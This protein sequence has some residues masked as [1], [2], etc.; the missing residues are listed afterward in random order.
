MIV[1]S[2]NPRSED[3][4]AIAESIA[5]DYAR[6]EIVLDRRAAIRRA[7]DQAQAG[8]TVVVA[9]KGHEAVSDRRR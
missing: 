5:V 9:G 6:T 7:I 3:P 2:D 4:L 8:D 1:T